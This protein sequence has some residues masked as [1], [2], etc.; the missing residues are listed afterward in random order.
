MN[1]SVV[2]A[3][4]A[5]FSNS[6]FKI[7]PCSIDYESGNVCAETVSSK[8]A[9]YTV[10]SNN[11]QAK[12]AAVYTLNITGNITSGKVYYIKIN[13]DSDLIMLAAEMAIVISQETAILDGKILDYTIQYPAVNTNITMTHDKKIYILGLLNI[14]DEN[15]FAVRAVDIAT[16]N[17]LPLT[18]EKTDDEQAICDISALINSAYRFIFEY[19]GQLVGGG[20][21]LSIVYNG[22]NYV[23]EEFIYFSLPNNSPYSGNTLTAN[24]IHTITGSGL[25]NIQNPGGRCNFYP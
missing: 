22:H 17:E 1:I 23:N 10:I 3:L 21:S 8:C 9:N 15:L 2:I 12:K 24:G 6:A 7:E 25:N 11:S 18:I 20:Y 5:V 4:L 13:I 19:D 14:P 16:G